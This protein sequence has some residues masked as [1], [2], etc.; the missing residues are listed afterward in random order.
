[1]K[2][3]NKGTFW[4]KIKPPEGTPTPKQQSFYE[5]SPQRVIFGENKAPGGN[6]DT[7][8]TELGFGNYFGTTKGILL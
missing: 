4:G 6:A 1:M 8:A 2:N 5:K 7:E 3:H